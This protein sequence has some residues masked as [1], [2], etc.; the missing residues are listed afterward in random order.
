M[1]I[2]QKME[3]DVHIH[4]CTC[5]TMWMVNGCALSATHT[6]DV[7]ILA[8]HL[9]KNGSLSLLY[10]C[11]CHCY[12]QHHSFFTTV[13][14]I[15]DTNVWQHVFTYFMEHFYQCKC[16]QYLP[17][18]EIGISPVILSCSIPMKYF[19]KKR[20]LWQEYIVK[21]VQCPV[22]A[23]LTLYIKNDSYMIHSLQT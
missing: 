6:R 7:G 16:I 5:I 10:T 18:Q 13:N 21:R 19:Y 17:S 3:F 14:I 1:I 9:Y 23:M 15:A 4:V 12:F 20:P 2:M 8:F 22:S 11:M